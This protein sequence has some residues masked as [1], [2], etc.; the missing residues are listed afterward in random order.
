[1]KNRMK[2]LLAALAIFTMVGC[3][4]KSPYDTSTPEKMLLSLGLV[5]AQPVDHNPVPYFYVKKDGIAI[6]NFDEAGFKALDAFESFK[7][8]MI[9][10]FQTKI[11]RSSKDKIEFYKDE[12]LFSTVSLSL[13]ASL[14]RPQLQNRSPEDYEVISVSEPSEHGVV[15]VKCRMMDRETDLEVK[16]EDGNYLM[17]LKDKDYVQIQKMTKFFEK[18]EALF[19]RAASEINNKEVTE[20]NFEEISTSWDTEYMDLFKELN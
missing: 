15:T 8:A 18:A 20:E 5:S 16:K 7:T 3:Q 6:T 2:Y 19:S 1:M 13:S 12:E 17:F 4:P 14:I 9:G 10:S 11:K